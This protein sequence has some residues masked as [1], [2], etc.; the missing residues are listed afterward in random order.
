MTPSKTY[1]EKWT[2][3][4]K[5]GSGGQATTFK[6][7]SKDGTL[8]GALKI[9]SRQKDPERRA[10]MYRETVALE[11]LIHPQ[12]P[13]MLDSNASCFNDLSYSLYMVTEY[14]P[15]G[16]LAENAKSKPNKLKLFETII[17]ITKVIGY[18]HK[19]GII[20]RDL[21]PDNIILRNSDWD[22][23][24]II[25]FGI[26]FNNEE[27]DNDDLTPSE[28][29]LG[30]R[31]LILPEQKVGGSGKR[32]MRSDITCCIGLLYF[33]IT[34]IYPTIL[35]D[36]SNNKPHQREGA[37]KIIN[38]LPKI[39]KDK[40]NS[41]FD[42]GFNYH[43]DKRI[44]SP[45]AL[46]LLLE[47]LLKASEELPKNTIEAIKSVIDDPEYRNLRNARWIFDET[48]RQSTAA[49][50]QAIN[51]LGR[52]E[53]NQTQ[54]GYDVNLNELTFKTTLGI[55]NLIKNTLKSVPL[56]TAY[57]TGSELVITAR[58]DNNIIELYRH[59]VNGEINWTQY[60]E[61]LTKYYLGK[62]GE[63]I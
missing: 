27:L 26:S 1:S 60:K 58:E 11:T 37:K 34:D 33:V 6:T 24:V 54:S 23:P 36:Q 50:T 21:K 45:D 18:C 19:R 44:Q 46:L 55:V 62:I 43:I 38:E 31:F 12:I 56:L 30:N 42:I 39:Y 3:Q 14:I 53:F 13:K 10:R 59:P 17:S 7:E 49:V 8:I 2:Q 51:Q 16:T 28:Q 40:L 25:D 22:D 32:D 41:L 35:L 20:H 48:Y 5:L 57:L 15:G 52:D 47:D 4:E 63:R 9:L 61:G 29:H